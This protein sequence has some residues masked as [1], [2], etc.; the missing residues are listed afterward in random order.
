MVNNSNRVSISPTYQMTGIKLY[1]CQSRK[2]TESR[3][4]LQKS[5][6]IH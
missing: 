3:N 2:E 6:F 4:N 5:R 1:P